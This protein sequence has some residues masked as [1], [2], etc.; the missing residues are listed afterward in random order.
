MNNLKL[1]AVIELGKVPNFGTKKLDSNSLDVI[2]F[3]E[4]NKRGMIVTKK[5]KLCTK[6]Y[7]YHSYTECS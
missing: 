6:C 2:A 1:H 7:T 4:L 5:D 3:R